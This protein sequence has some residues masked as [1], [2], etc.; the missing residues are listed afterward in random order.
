MY[1]YRIHPHAS[2]CV[3]RVDRSGIILPTPFRLFHKF[4]PRLFFPPFPFGLSFSLSHKYPYIFLAPVAQ[5][6]RKKAEA[7]PIRALPLVW[8]GLVD[9]RN[10]IC[11]SFAV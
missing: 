7:I 8:S 10:I 9:A 4:Q 1:T 5:P 6:D 11:I 2:A 3:V